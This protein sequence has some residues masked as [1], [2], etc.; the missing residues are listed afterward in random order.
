MLRRWDPS[1][2][3]AGWRDRATSTTTTGIRSRHDFACQLAGVIIVPSMLAELAP[4]PGQIA[5][6]KNFAWLGR[7]ALQ[8][9]FLNRM[10]GHTQF[11]CA[12]FPRMGHFLS[13]RKAFLRIGGRGLDEIREFFRTEALMQCKIAVRR[14]R[15]GNRPPTRLRHALPSGVDEGIAGHRF[16]TAPAGIEAVELTLPMH[17]D[18]A[19]AA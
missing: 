18:E 10:V 9:I 11:G 15:H 6:A 7:L 3:S 4:S 19:I 8:Q 16:R 2:P 14:A 1:I 13:N 12:P 17:Q 5:L